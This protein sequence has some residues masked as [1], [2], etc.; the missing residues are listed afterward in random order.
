MR[1]HHWYEVGG[2]AGGCTFGGMRSTSCGVTIYNDEV[3]WCV[4]V[5]KR[6][7]RDAAFEARFAHLRHVDDRLA[8][9]GYAFGH[10][11]SGTFY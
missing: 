2:G 11:N 1:G 3:G 5:A 4:T 7:S 6:G 9:V 10:A 8:V